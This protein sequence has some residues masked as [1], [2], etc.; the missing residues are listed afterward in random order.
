MRTTLSTVS[1]I[2]SPQ[3]YVKGDGR[4]GTARRG[5]RCEHV[6]ILDVELGAVTHTDDC[7]ALEIAPSRVHSH[8]ATEGDA[9]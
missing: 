8:T 1:R 5:R 9:C 4:R 6:A 2:D 3:R 7:R